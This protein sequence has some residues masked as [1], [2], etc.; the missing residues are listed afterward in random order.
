MYSAASSQDWFSSAH[1]SDATGVRQRPISPLHDCADCFR[2]TEDETWRSCGSGDCLPDIPVVGPECTEDCIVVH[3]AE[4]HLGNFCDDK[5][6][7][8][9][10]HPCDGWGAGWMCDGPECAASHNPVSSPCRLFQPKLVQVQYHGHGPPNG[11]KSSFSDPVDHVSELFNY[12]SQYDL[13]HAQENSHSLQPLNH[14]VPESAQSSSQATMRDQSLSPLFSS[15]FSPPTPLLQPPLDPNAICLWDAC[16]QL[17]PSQLDLFG[18]IQTSHLGGPLAQDSSP[19]CRWDNCQIA[20]TP[21]AVPGF[22]G[23]AVPDELAAI[24]SQHVLDSHLKSSTAPDGAVWM[25]AQP[26]QSPVVQEQNGALAAV[27][28]PEQQTNTSQIHCCRWQECDLVFPTCEALTAH[29]NTDHVGSGK[30]QYPC[31]WAG[32][33][34]SGDQAFTSKQKIMR[35]LQAST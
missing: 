15:D 14:L 24:L 25:S 1:A 6:N 27:A 19:F 3:C 30:P 21:Y 31:L 28:R 22:S 11:P 34:R 33:T 32:C 10:D 5:C 17:F 9:E 18:H 2:F 23:N 16:N 7:G 13:A 20:P 35:H 26:L 4:P 8:T 29:I 12:G